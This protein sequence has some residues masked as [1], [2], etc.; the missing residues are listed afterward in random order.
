MDKI[1]VVTGSSKGIG[2]AIAMAFASSGEYGAVVTNARKLEEALQ[3][4][5]EVK[6]TGRCD[7]VAIEADVSKEDDCVRLVDE[8]ARRYGRID[9]LVNNA[10]VQREIPF[11]ET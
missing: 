3:V 2:R 10:G 4:A 1:A 11:E 7:S 8:T 9:V 5:E 6:R